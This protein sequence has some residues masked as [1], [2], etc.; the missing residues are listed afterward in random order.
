MEAYSVLTTV[1]AKEDPEFLRASI[2]SMLNQT[3]LTDDYVIVK[4]GP[5]TP[6][7]DVVLE[8]YAQ[9]HDCF[10]IVALEENVGLGA[11]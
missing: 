8:S 6:A 10:H 3:V 11:A 4:D 2:E 1:Y 5:L 9:L 7:L